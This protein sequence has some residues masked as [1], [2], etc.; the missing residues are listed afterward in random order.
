MEGASLLPPSPLARLPRTSTP[1]QRTRACLTDPTSQPSHSRKV[2]LGLLVATPSLS[3]VSHQ[4]V[5]RHSLVVPNPKLVEP[6]EVGAQRAKDSLPPALPR[7]PLPRPR[8]RVLPEALN[9][10]GTGESARL[11]FKFSF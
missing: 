2:S 6:G 5:P 3:A 10:A 11:E 9:T 8:L 7:G 4:A 1:L